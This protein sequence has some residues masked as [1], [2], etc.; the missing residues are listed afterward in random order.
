MSMEMLIT[1]GVQ[2]ISTVLGV[3]LAARAAHKNTVDF[4]VIRSDRD[5]YFMRTA[6]LDEFKDNLD[7]AEKQATDVDENASTLYKNDAESYKLQSYVWETMKQQ[8][9]TFQLPSDIL[10]GVRRYYDAA[11]THAM[12]M[13]EGQA[14]ARMAALAA[15]EDTKKM[16]ETLVPRMEKD[17][18]ELGAKLRRRGILAE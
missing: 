3:Y 17:I 2:L 15:I 6:L 11:T 16:R 4:E 12:G 9:I 18:A 13:A 5:G 8:G 1:S 14:A 10:T 7:Q